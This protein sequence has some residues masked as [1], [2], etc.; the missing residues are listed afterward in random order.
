VGAAR[1]L[2]VIV[3]GLGM[4]LLI[5]TVY[6]TSYFWLVVCFAISTLAY[7]AFSTMMLN[8]PAD[9]YPT[10]S[11]ASVSG[12]GGT[13]AGIGTIAATYATGIVSD[14]YSFEPIL[15]AA[16]I[17]P[18]IAMIAVLLLVRNNRAA[19]QGIVNRL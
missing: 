10:G 1:K 2:V 8:L 15:I 5:P 11:V 18:V 13:G 17:I 12:M 4:T 7:A 6:T 16:S 14:R 19:E 3:S 9:I